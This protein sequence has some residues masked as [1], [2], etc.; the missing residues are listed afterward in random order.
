[1]NTEAIV[2][3]AAWDSFVEL[4]RKHRAVGIARYELVNS[5]RPP[6][7]GYYFNEATQ[8][9]LPGWYRDLNPYPW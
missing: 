2:D 9:Y 7:E 6:P 8:F 1:M 3:Q 5:N 4:C